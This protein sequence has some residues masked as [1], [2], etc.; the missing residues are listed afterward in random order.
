MPIVRAGTGE[1]S[2]YIHTFHDLAGQILS[3]HQMRWPQ[4]W[5]ILSNY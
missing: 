1:R 5:A 4:L 3:K 2:L